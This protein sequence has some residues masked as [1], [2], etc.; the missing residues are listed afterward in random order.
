MKFMKAMKE[1]KINFLY[2]GAA[3]AKVFAYLAAGFSLL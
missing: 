3:G 1:C 2:L